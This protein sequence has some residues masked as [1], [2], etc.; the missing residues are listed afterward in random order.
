M[1]I[2]LHANSIS[3]VEDDFLRNFTIPPTIITIDKN[4]T[5]NFI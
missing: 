5:D 4:I 1:Q 3:S 2:N